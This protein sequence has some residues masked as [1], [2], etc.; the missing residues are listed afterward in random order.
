M[1]RGQKLNVG[2]VFDDSLDSSDGVAQHLK[3]LGAWLSSQGHKVSY[4]VGET[5]MDKWAG[6]RVYSLAKN[7]TVN[8]NGNKLSMP[9]FPDRSMI[10]KVLRESQ[11][12]VLHVMVPYSPFM[13][14]KAIKLSKNTAV[15]GTFHIYP[16]GRLSKAGSKLLRLVYLNNLSKFSQFISVSAAAAAFARQTFKIRS[17]IIPNPIDLKAFKTHK[18]INYAEQRVVFLGRLVNRKGCEEL[19]RA[20]ALLK[21]RLPSTRL[22]IAGDGA[23]RQKLEKLVIKLD[24]ADRTEFLGFI[25]ENKKAE[26]LASADVACFPS[27]YGESFGIV[28]I[29]AMASGAGVVIGGDNPGYRSVLEKQPKLLINPKNTQEFAERLEELMTNRTLIKKLHAW[30]LSTVRQ[31][32]I[33]IVGPQIFDVYKQAIARYTEKD[34]N[35]DYGK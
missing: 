10:K 18:K 28:L 4:L 14:Q 3:V 1:P 24:I 5:K 20:F 21:D 19:L 2:L 22:V 33:N 16:S 29:E 12:D 34:H 17:I 9:I 31:Y 11:F 30:Q 15:V 25:D 26:L 35:N 6:G 23:E 13:A 7:K 32:D 27:L 8:F